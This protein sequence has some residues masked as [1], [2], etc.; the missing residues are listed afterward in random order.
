[1]PEA[2]GVG[3]KQGTIRTV[4]EKVIVLVAVAALPFA[5]GNGQAPGAWGGR[6]LAQSPR[7]D[8]HPYFGRGGAKVLW[9]VYDTEVE[10]GNTE[11]FLRRLRSQDS[12]WSEP[13]RLTSDP[14]ADQ[15]PAVE[16]VGDSAL[17]VWESNRRGNWDLMYSTF[18]SAGWSSPDFVTNDEANEREPALASPPMWVSERWGVRV[19]LV[20]C[21][22]GVLHAATFGGDRWQ[23]LDRLPRPGPVV[24]EIYNTVGQKVRTLVNEPKAAGAH[25]VPWDGRD[26]QGREMPGG[27][28]LCRLFAGSAVATKKLVL[29]R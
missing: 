20:F 7:D 24:L 12:V 2:M 25:T 9:L 13:V 22:E 29:T 19:L 17:V 21:K 28:Y 6:P 15:N 8:R 3:A 11:V 16:L 1:M 5:R 14:G 27:V 10:P 26:E 4:R 23:F 18:G